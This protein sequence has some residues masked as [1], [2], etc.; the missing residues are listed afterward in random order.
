[1]DGTLKGIEL[2]EANHPPTACHGIVF[3]DAVIE[4]ELRLH[5]VPLDG[6]KSRYMHVRA[7]D[8]RDYVLAAIVGPGG[9]TVRRPTTTIPQRAGPSLCRSAPPPCR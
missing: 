7:T 3:K 5:D 9:L 6:R 1:V 4:C 8:V 2:A